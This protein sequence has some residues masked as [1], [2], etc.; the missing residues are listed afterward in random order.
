MPASSAPASRRTFL[1]A[2]LAVAAPFA[3]RAAMADQ[4][5]A[6]E[7]ATLLVAGPAGGMMDRWADRLIDLLGENLPGTPRLKKLVSGGIDGVT[8]ANQFDLRSDP[9]GMTVMLAP[10]ASQLAWLAGDPRAKF[11]AGHW[12][13]LLAAVTP[14][15]ICA[16][17]GAPG[18]PPAAGVRVAM[19][20]PA[21]PEL[22]TFLALEL[23]GVKPVPVQGLRDE[24]AARAAYAAGTVDVL[25]IGG[26]R[27]L[28][29]VRA[30]TGAGAG[31]LFSLGAL[32]D[33]GAPIRE[34]QF[35][36]LPHAAELLASRRAPGV[37]VGLAGVLG[38]VLASAQL[39]MGL[40]LPH[41]T[42]AAMVA[43][44]RSAASQ[45]AASPTL[46]AEAFSS[47]FRLLQ[48][49]EASVPM[50]ALTPA[51]AAL[52]DLR[53]WMAERLNWRPKS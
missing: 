25:T 27:V 31:P 13:P 53:R 49:P 43:P 3:A 24:A 42:P 2:G 22:A 48:S 47:G 39:E 34:P 29:R 7:G 20:E 14:T 46:L 10:G 4:V 52:P 19:S 9:D 32:D 12:V 51:P 37:P 50:A 23:M 33:A 18:R 6:L 21:G 5:A 15:V 26:K 35:P 45:A 44:W 17:G 28:D 1:K 40:V 11:E 38:A 41:L 8:A 30:L 36:D 16:R